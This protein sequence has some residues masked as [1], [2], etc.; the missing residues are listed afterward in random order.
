MRPGAVDESI[1]TVA[2]LYILLKAR[3][4]LYGN[5]CV[6]G[7]NEVFESQYF[8]LTQWIAAREQVGCAPAAPTVPALPIVPVLLLALSI[9]GTSSRCS[10]SCKRQQRR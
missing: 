10:A 6:R 7:E 2:V 3:A 8:T 1:R 9:S 5:Y 4:S